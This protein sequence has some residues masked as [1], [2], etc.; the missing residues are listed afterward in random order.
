[1]QQPKSQSQKEG[2]YGEYILTGPAP[3]QLVEIIIQNTQG[4]YTRRLETSTRNAVLSVLPTL[5]LW[6]SATAV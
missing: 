5:K 2:H 1:M 3:S 6:I 4:P